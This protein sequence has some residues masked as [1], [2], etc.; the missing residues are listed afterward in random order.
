MTYKA[1]KIEITWLIAKFKVKYTKLFCY[2]VDQ[3]PIQIITYTYKT[4]FRRCRQ[5]GTVVHKDRL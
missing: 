4:Y 1:T 2:S 5:D 3:K